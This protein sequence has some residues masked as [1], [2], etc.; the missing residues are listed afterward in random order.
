MNSMLKVIK[1]KKTNFLDMSKF[2]GLNADLSP[3]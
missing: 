1:K 2:N 3:I